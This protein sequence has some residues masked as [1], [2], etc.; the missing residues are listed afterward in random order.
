MFHVDSSVASVVFWYLEIM[1]LE[2]VMGAEGQNGRAKVGAAPSS[3]RSG[4]ER[5]PGATPEGSPLA[6][7]FGSASEPS[8]GGGGLLRSLPWKAYWRYLWVLCSG[9]TDPGSQVKI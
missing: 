3:P 9:N 5:A 8:A 7:S 6:P 1:I 2:A 4:G